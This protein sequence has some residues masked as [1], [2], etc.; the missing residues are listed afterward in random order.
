ME[1]E[2]E[3]VAFD[4]GLRQKLAFATIMPE[5]ISKKLGEYFLQKLRIN[6]QHRIARLNLPVN[7][8]VFLW[9]IVV[10]FPA[11]VFH[12]IGSPV[13]NQGWSHL[14]DVFGKPL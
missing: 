3:P 11:Q 10:N 14:P 7:F 9:E 13:R 8:G 2:K 5:S 4:F 6:A 12:E 1:H